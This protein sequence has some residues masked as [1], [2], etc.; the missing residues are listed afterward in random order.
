MLRHEGLHVQVDYQ[1]PTC[2]YQPEG[3]AGVKVRL[4]ALAALFPVLRCTGT[5]VGP[6]DGLAALGGWLVC[7]ILSFGFGPPIFLCSPIAPVVLGTPYDGCTLCP[8]LSQIVDCY[9]VQP[10][11][12]GLQGWALNSKEGL[13]VLHEVLIYHA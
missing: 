4:S 1:P 9:E 11:C 2:S 3:Q 13:H 5:R 7:P 6:L 8:N 12:Q 10:S